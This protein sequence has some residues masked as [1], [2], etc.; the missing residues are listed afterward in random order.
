M[1]YLTSNF[2]KTIV[3]GAYDAD[4]VSITVL[5]PERF[6]AAPFLAV[7]WNA[8][9]YGDPSDDPSREIVLVTA[10][11]DDVFTVTR[12]QEGT[13]ASVKNL[14]DKVYKLVAGI[15]AAMWND[16]AGTSLGSVMRFVTNA[17]TPESSVT[18]PVGRFCVDTSNDD[19]YYKKTGSGNTGWVNL[20]V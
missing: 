20:T 10:V 14:A 16:L 3:D 5:D 9:D 7:W 8:T 4:D 18:A 17:G 2:A 1:S 11:T 15:T 6:P 12:A 13:T 19:L